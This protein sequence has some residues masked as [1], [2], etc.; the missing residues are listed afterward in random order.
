MKKKLTV[1][2]MMLMLVSMMLAACGK[3]GEKSA[4][5][6]TWKAK[7]VDAAGVSMD[8]DAYAKQTGV[9]MDMSITFKEDKSFSMDAVG[10]KTEGTWVEKESKITATADG[11]DQT[12]QLE[13]GKLVYQDAS[14]GDV[15]ITFE[16]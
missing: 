4:V 1:V 2:V 8:L 7:S 11:Q 16:K 5:V 14:M 13:D 6:G 10:Q 9:T 15:K 3:G 12:F